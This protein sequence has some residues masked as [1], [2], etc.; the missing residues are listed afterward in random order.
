MAVKT[1]SLKDLALN[2]GTPIRGADHPLPP[3]FPRTIAPGARANIDRVLDSGFGLDIIKEY[4]VAFAAAM[5][6]KHAV[7][8]S[9][10]TD[11]LHAVVAAIGVGPGDEV[12]AS[13]ITDYGSVKG[14][15][16]Q[17]A[18]AVFPDVDVR[19]GLITADEIAKVITSRTKAIIAVHMYGQV[20]DM[21]PIVE[22]A[23]KHDLL[24]IEDV[25]QAPFAKYKGR[26][27]GTIGDVGCYSFEAE[28]HIS[29]DHG[30]MA[31]TDDGKLADDIRF[32]ALSR[33][34][35]PAE[36]GT[37]VHEAI[38]HA[39]R[40]GRLEAAVGLAQLP[41]VPE[42]NR[43]RVK[44]ANRLSQGLKTI[45]GISP[46]F[47]PSNTSHV[48]WLYH[49][50]VDLSQFG[51]DLGEFIDAL[52]A[53]GLKCGPALYYLIPYSHTFVKNREEILKRLPNAREHL[54][55]TIRWPW[56]EKYSESDVDD[57]AAIVRKVADAYR[58]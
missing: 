48:Y 40:Y 54:S 18:E 53:E 58:V 17:G 26:V 24:L 23:R 49:F 45:D 11:A 57:I 29:T 22:L 5:G 41:L 8:L 4:E 32:I 35:R 38:G 34:A 37:R 50:R 56:T 19:T 1:T 31:I 15:F 33:G 30:G 16:V 20:C 52:N 27:T 9:N 21:D 12:I 42:Q 39:F 10:C 44:L 3:L 55:N 13:P 25:C 28:K 47:V 6:T 46:P 43:L 7:A 2:G 36:R 51:V 14:I